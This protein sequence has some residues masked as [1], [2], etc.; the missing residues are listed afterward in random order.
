MK[1]SSLQYLMHYS[2]DRNFD[3]DVMSHFR[4]TKFPIQKTS[5]VCFGI[6]ICRKWVQISYFS[7]IR[8]RN[9]N[10]SGFINVPFLDRRSDKKF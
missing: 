9:G 7:M 3:F 2:G 1:R 8:F 5:L 4:A 10:S 6:D